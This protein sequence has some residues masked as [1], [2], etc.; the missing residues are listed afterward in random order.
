MLFNQLCKYLKW[1]NFL[2]NNFSRSITVHAI[3][4]ACIVFLLPP[5][6]RRNFQRCNLL[7]LTCIKFIFDVPAVT[8]IRDKNTRESTREYSFIHTKGSWSCSGIK[9]WGRDLGLRWTKEQN[10]AENHIMKMF[11]FVGLTK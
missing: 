6:L 3:T 2:H 11:I 4:I 9:C 10:A 1:I 7:S 5:S 8:R